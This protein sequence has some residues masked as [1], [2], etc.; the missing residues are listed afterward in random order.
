MKNYS[1]FIDQG[2]KKKYKGVTFFQKSLIKDF[3]QNRKFHH[4]IV[5]NEKNK[6]DKVIKNDETYNELNNLKKKKIN[7]NL[8]KKIFIFYKKFEVNLSLKKKYSKNFR[9]KTNIETSICSYVILGILL[10]KCRNLDI[11]QKINCVLKILDKVL[12]KHENIK[13]CNYIN[14]NSLIL[15]ENNIIRKIIT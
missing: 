9:K 1:H 6:Y 3:F 13:N 4:K 10:H 2:L 14:L 8:E 11:Y 12:I 7:K 5:L 15:L